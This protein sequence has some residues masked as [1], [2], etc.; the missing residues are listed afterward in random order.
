MNHYI[1][2]VTINGDWEGGHHGQYPKVFSV[3][4][5]ESKP[6]VVTEGSGWGFGGSS[7][8]LAELF[9]QDV[10]SIFDREESSELFQLLWSGYQSGVSSE[11]LAKELMERY[12]KHA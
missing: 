1:E 3:S 4:P 9:E 10:A 6:F 2:L 5:G 8:T 7:F 12:G 11:A